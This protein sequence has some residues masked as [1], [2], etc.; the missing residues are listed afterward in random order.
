MA[1]SEIREERLSVALRST[2]MFRGLS[3]AEL[4]RLKAI[5]SL[6]DYARGE[7]IW[8][9]GDSADA[10]T[11]IVKGRVKIVRHGAG[12]D[13]ILEIFDVGEPVGAIAV[14]DGIPYPA[15]AIAIEAVTLIRIPRTEYFH[16]LDKHPEFA[17]AVMRELTRLSIALTRKLGD[18]RGQRVEM[19]IAR[20]FLTLAARMGRPAGEG[21]EIP[22]QLTRQEVAELVSTTVE[23]AIRTLS[24]WGR[25]ELVITRESSFTIPSLAR[26]KAVAEGGETGSAEP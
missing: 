12:G 26:L 5:A 22:I 24:R 9:A 14:Y 10:F 18:M 15:S 19:R 8:S 2:P 20:L 16:L 6:R 11:L 21:V 4:A 1:R 7:T 23:S 13:V 3:P 25:E 17:R